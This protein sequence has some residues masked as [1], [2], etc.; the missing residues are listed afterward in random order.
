[1][2]VPDEPETPEPLKRNDEEL[3]PNEEFVVHGGVE[4]S[5]PFADWQDSYTDGFI[6][7]LA[8]V[9]SVD[10]SRINVT[11]IRPG[12][13]IIDYTIR[14]VTAVVEEEALDMTR[15]LG[16]AFQG[17]FAEILH[18]FGV[19]EC[20]VNVSESQL[21]SVKRPPARSMGCKRC[22]NGREQAEHDHRT[23]TR[24]C[25]RGGK[26][27]KETPFTIKEQCATGC[28]THCMQSCRR[29]HDPKV[30]KCAAAR[31]SYEQS[32]VSAALQPTQPPPPQ[33]QPEAVVVA[34]AGQNVRLKRFIAEAVTE[35]NLAQVSIDDSRE[36]QEVF[37]LAECYADCS[38]QCIEQCIGEFGDPIP[39]DF[40]AP[41]PEPNSPYN[42][43]ALSPAYL[44]GNDTVVA[45]SQ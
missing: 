13:T 9:C 2:L 21:P 32:T 22:R 17:D 3:I 10:A 26:C 14:P 19:P 38:R 44:P 4:I 37:V 33:Q 6:K 16:N 35:Q 30:R 8:D 18:S 20:Y 15:K 34:D 25:G 31:R 11:D 27:G 7:A 24:K 45:P 28:A 23:F 40:I 39:S 5:I 42:P 43:P 1:L 29:F 36:R 12:S 41:V